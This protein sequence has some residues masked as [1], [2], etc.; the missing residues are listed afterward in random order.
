MDLVEAAGAPVSGFNDRSLKIFCDLSGRVLCSLYLFVPLWAGL[1]LNGDAV[2]CCTTMIITSNT[3]THRHTILK[4]D[5]HRRRVIKS[6]LE[7][8]GFISAYLLSSRCSAF[9]FLFLE[10]SGQSPA[11]FYSVATGISEEAAKDKADA[12]VRNFVRL[13]SQSPWKPR[14]TDRERRGKAR[15]KGVL[16][17]PRLYRFPTERERVPQ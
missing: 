17:P 12:I 14:I 6:W 5:C 1:P 16:F 8:R 9:V 7:L 10:G 4:L 13:P 2:G 15:R 11:V 3:Q